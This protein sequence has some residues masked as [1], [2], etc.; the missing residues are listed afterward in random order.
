MADVACFCGCL[1]WFDGGA[2]ACPQ[3][4][5]YAAVTA[6]DAFLSAARSQQ[7]GP[8]SLTNADTDGPDAKPEHR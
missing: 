4:G 6:A 1:Y 7:Q 2:G 8:L 5:E 3:C